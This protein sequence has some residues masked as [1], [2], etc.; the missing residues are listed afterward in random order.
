MGRPTGIC[1]A[2]ALSVLALLVG[3][4]CGSETIDLL[5]SPS[6]GAGTGGGQPTAGAAGMDAAPTGQGG[7]RAGA[8]GAGGMSCTAEN[9]GA[10]ANRGGDGHSPFCPNGPNC[11]QCSSN[12]D[13]SGQAPHCA[14]WLGNTCVECTGTEHCERGFRC[15]KSTGRCAEECLASSDCSALDDFVC[16]VP[17][18]ICAECL[19]DL[20]CMEDGNPETTRCVGRRCFA[21]YSN[22]DCVGSG[23]PYCLGFHCAECVLDQHCPPDARCHLGRGRCEQR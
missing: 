10:T 21:C 17:Q 3:L 4:S 8:T 1:Q 13:C 9:C 2:S 5:A 15:D 19:V 18:G 14:A 23:R 6:V 22:D 11:G 7:A 12:E 20:D 16:D